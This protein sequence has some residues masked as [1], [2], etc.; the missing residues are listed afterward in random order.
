MPMQDGNAL[1]ERKND[2]MRSMESIPVQIYWGMAMASVL[3]SAVLYLLG[4]RSTALFVGQWP[5]TLLAMALLYK[6][7]RPSQEDASPLHD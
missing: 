3:L 5:P 4:R 2:L 6:L 1:V 7:L